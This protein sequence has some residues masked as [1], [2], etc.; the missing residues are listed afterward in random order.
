M[1]KNSKRHFKGNNR[2]QDKAYRREKEAKWKNVRGDDRDRDPTSNNNNY[3]KTTLE[4]P[5]MELF[6]KA[7]KFVLE[8]EWN[9]FVTS[10]RSPLPACFRLN[11]DYVFV[12]QL[13][14]QLTKFVGEKQFVSNRNTSGGNI[15]IEI[16]PV[17]QLLWYPNNVGYQMGTDRRSIRKSP[18]LEEL[19]KWMV[20]HT[21]NGNI[22]RQEAVSMVPPLA[23]N[24]EPHHKCLSC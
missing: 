2:S 3:N 15:S 11:S 16:H 17:K 21:E 20:T 24:V 7:Q 19:H 23:L 5:R 22:T 12:D 18:E 13:R 4:N 9:D 10:L 1:G 6:Y 14:K 8:N